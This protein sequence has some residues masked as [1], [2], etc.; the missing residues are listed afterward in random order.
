M[1]TRVPLKAGDI[2]A[3]KPENQYNELK[4]ND[5]SGGKLFPRQNVLIRTAWEMQMDFDRPVDPEEQAITAAWELAS[6][7][8]V[9]LNKMNEISNS[10][11][12]YI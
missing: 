8:F 9:H 1:K 4:L 10:K 11:Y 5:T 3:I 6:G 2:A 7:M 12:V